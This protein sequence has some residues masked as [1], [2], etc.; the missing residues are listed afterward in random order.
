MSIKVISIKGM[1]VFFEKEYRDVVLK[2]NE[3]YEATKNL[4]FEGKVFSGK[5]IRSIESVMS[6]LKKKLQQHV[7]FDE[8]IIFPFLETNIPK[9]EPVLRFLRAERNEFK[10][11]PEEFDV[12]FQKVKE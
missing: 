8:K 2:L 3:L 4:H 12:L 10:A 7:A 1:V 6:Y 5:N 9:L 11:N